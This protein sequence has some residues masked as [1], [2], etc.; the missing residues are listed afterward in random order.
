MQGTEY[1]HVNITSV[2]MVEC[3]HLVIF[4]NLQIDLS[5]NQVV[6]S[7]VYFHIF[8]FPSELFEM[9]GCWP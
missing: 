7:Y 5:I 9:A 8:L 1:G 3:F 6:D 2:I 4:D